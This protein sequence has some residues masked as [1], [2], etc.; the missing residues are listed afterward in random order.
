MGICCSLW[1]SHSWSPC[2]ALL[3]RGSVFGPLRSATALVVPS[4]ISTVWLQ[5][6]LPQPFHSH[7]P[8]TPPTAVPSV[9][10]NFSVMLLSST[11]VAVFFSPHSITFLHLSLFPQC[12]PAQKLLIFPSRLSF[13]PPFSSGIPLVYLYLLVCLFSPS[14]HLLTLLPLFHHTSVCNH[15]CS[16]QILSLPRLFL[17]WSLL[18]PCL[19]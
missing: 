13:F 14:F 8:A 16:L 9:P 4:H 10:P 18:T 2:S 17:S 15:S 1:P 19:S 11:T 3:T 6:P 12:S 5:A 7:F